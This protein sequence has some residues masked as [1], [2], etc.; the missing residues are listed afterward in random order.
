MKILTYLVAIAAIMAG[1]WFSYD[2]M[3][4]FTKL[5]S[6]R[7][8]LDKQNKTRSAFIVKTKSEAKTME[9]ERDKAQQALA[10]SEAE[11]ANTIGNLNFSKRE[12]ASWKAKIDEQDNQLAKVEEV[13]ANIKEQFKAVAGDVRIEEVPDLVKQLEED[14]KAANRKLE[15][16]Q[17]LSAAANKRVEANNAEIADLTGR[18]DKRAERIAS[19]S[20]VGS[21]SAI[22]HDWGFAI[23]DIPADMTLDQSS[24]LIVKRGPVYIGK[25]EINSVEGG[26]LLADVDYQSMTPGMVVQPGDSVLLAKPFTN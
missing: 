7:I 10:E 12:A 15:D 6:D 8:E 24:K 21:V 26:R 3:N 22:N 18:I 25:L 1:A 4:K 17:V 11:L 16:L 20:L 23:V 19:N 5:Q 2:T 9:G 13:I 14:L